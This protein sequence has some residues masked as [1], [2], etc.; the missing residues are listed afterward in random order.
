MPAF[1]RRLVFLQAD[2]AM[3]PVV[4]EI[5][6][7]KLLGEL[8]LSAAEKFLECAFR[9]CLVLFLQ[10]GSKKD[11]QAKNEQVLIKRE[12]FIRFACRREA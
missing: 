10:R 9:E 1:Q 5:F 2:I 11:G 6:G 12:V 7:I 8:E 3:D 4:D